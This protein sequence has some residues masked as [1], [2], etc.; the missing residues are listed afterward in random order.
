MLI[1]SD[2]EYSSWPQL[3]VCGSQLV[4]AQ[5]VTIMLHIIPDQ[6]HQLQL[7]QLLQLPHS[8][9]SPVLLLVTR[10]QQH[11]HWSLQATILNHVHFD[12]F[13]NLIY[14]QASHPAAV[15]QLYKPAAQRQKAQKMA[16]KIRFTRS[17]V[18]ML[19][20]ISSKQ[21]QNVNFLNL[22]QKMM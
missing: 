8:C 2:P 7:L 4:A 5:L 12:L 14:N 21:M 19:K 1:V 13:T 22:L 9:S 20:C 17:S 3:W 6:T 10:L 16:P 18:D 11:R 15:Q